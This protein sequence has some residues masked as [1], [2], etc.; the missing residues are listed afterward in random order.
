M[1]NALPAL[2]EHSLLITRTNVLANALKDA[3]SVLETRTHA[4]NALPA[5]IYQDLHAKLVMLVNMP[6]LSQL[7]QDHA[8]VA[9]KPT[10]K[11]VPPLL[12]S[13]LVPPV[14]INTIFLQAPARLVQL[15]TV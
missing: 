12:T 7:P 2:L 15:A 5:T 4:L 1:V 14:T 3:L 6:P 13:R 8:L 10:V 9:R 11:L